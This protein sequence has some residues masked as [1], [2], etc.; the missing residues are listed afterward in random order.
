MRAS[1]GARDLLFIEL[2]SLTAHN[3][4]LPVLILVYEFALLK[5]RCLA[6]LANVNESRL[7]GQSTRVVAP[8]FAAIAVADV[9]EGIIVAP[10]IAAHGVRAAG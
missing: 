7:H 2:L 8:S 1:Q 3:I 10:A 9:F 6:W 5:H 4:H